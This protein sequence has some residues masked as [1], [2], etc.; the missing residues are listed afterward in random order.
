MC[1]LSK[2]AG[3]DGSGGRRGRSCLDKAQVGPASWAGGGPSAEMRNKGEG[4]GLG[5]R[6]HGVN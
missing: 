6:R 2:K 4:T 3:F 1:P 5:K